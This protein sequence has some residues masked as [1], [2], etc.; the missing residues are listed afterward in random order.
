MKRYLSAVLFFSVMMSCVMPA[1]AASK[2]PRTT[3][4]TKVR[5]SGEKGAYQVVTK[6]TVVGKNGSVSSGTTVKTIRPKR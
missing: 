3:T 2:A 1:F 4:Q 6:K 5:K